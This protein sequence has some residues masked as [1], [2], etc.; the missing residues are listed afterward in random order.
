[1][2]FPT[3]DPLQKTWVQLSSAAAS[4]KAHCLEFNTASL[5]GPVSASAIEGIFTRLGEFRAYASSVAA[6]PGLAAY[7]QAQ[8]NDAQLDIAAEY[9]AMLGQIDSAL[10]WMVANVPAS[11]GYVLLDQWA[12]NGTISRR[13]FSTASLAGLRATLAS[14]ASTIE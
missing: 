14:V 7:V 9:T 5:A 4:L 12:T 10:A 3:R 6:K 2:A 8:Y 1:M 13:A 11:G